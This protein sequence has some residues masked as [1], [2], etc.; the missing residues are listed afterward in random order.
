MTSGL[1][2]STKFDRVDDI[3]NVL[4][5][6]ISTSSSVEGEKLAPLFQTKALKCHYCTMLAVICG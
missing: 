2:V 3:A 4:A 1:L 5:H 6:I